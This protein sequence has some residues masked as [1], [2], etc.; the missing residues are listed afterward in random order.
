VSI[1]E[2]KQSVIVDAYAW[3]DLLECIAEWHPSPSEFSALRRIKINGGT[4]IRITVEE[5][6]P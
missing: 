5:V 1:E 4:R 3:S 2:N 6:L